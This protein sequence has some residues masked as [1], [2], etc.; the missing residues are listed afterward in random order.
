MKYTV[1]SAAEFTYPD[2]FD[3][4][5]SAEC[6]DVFAA[7][8]GRAAFQV[9][10]S[11]LAETCE[12]SVTF[13]GLPTGVVPEVYALRS[14]MVERNH[15]LEPEKFAPHYP[16]RVAPYRV[17]DCLCPYGGSLNPEQGV[18]G[19][20]VALHIARETVPGK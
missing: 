11:G 3:Y 20:Y 2:I 7:R 1:V 16:E 8:G 6:A 12:L 9:L 18:A 13:E 17:Y 14:V 5:S 4:P 15:G 19:L 10:I